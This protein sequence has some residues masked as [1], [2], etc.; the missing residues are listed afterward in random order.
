[1]MTT[2]TFSSNTNY[3]TFWVLLL[4]CL[5]YVSTASHPL[6]LALNK[7][8][9]KTR[10]LGVAV[11]IGKVNLVDT[12]KDVRTVSMGLEEAVSKTC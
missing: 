10:E 6:P 1:M 11:A 2:C 8:I 3:S 4:L 9:D 5:L 12:L 7:E